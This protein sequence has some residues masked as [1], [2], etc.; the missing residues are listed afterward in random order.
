MP[1]SAILALSFFLLAIVTYGQTANGHKNAIPDSIVASIRKLGVNNN[2]GYP[3][4]AI[5][6]YKDD[7]I[8]SLTNF[9]DTSK[10]KQGKYLAVFTLY[11]IGINNRTGYGG[12]YYEEFV[13]KNARKAMLRYIGDS[14]LTKGVVDELLQDPWI[15]DIPVFM[16][17]L[18]KPSADYIAILDALKNYSFKGSPFVKKVPRDS[19]SAYFY[20]I[21]GSKLNVYDPIK[22]REIWLNWWAHLTKEEK[23]R[24]YQ[25]NSPSLFK[26]QR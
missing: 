23:A 1:R 11:L 15:T 10:N 3:I 26:I 4:I 6:S 8:H 13:N 22:A 16:D 12:G 19:V 14:L 25:N 18:S 9:L 17:Y 7:A 21:N 24:F 2:I 20:N 5:I